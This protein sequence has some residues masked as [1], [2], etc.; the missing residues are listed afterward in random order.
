MCGCWPPECKWVGRPRHP[1]PRGAPVVLEG[2]HPARIKMT[3]YPPARDTDS[4][5]R[6]R[7]TCGPV[8]GWRNHLRPRGRPRR[9][10]GDDS[11]SPPSC[12]RRHAASWAVSL[13]GL[14][15][16]TPDL[17]AEFAVSRASSIRQAS[18]RS[19]PTPTGP[20][21]CR[22]ATPTWAYVWVLVA[23]R[24]DKNSGS[25]RNSAVPPGTPCVSLDARLT[26]RASAA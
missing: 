26:P 3:R 13:R 16:S 8:R 10:P 17:R 24:G 7:R 25:M 4:R 15:A 19:A 2:P 20:V 23:L 6:H 21:R 11:T 14:T 22:S 18:S 5:A 12:W 9:V 1:Q